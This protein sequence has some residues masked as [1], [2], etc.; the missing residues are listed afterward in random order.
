MTYINFVE[1][2]SLMLQ[3]HRP[4]GSG[5]EDFLKVL[6]IYSH[7]GHLG[8]VTWIIYINFLS[9]FIRMLHM[10][11]GFD[12]QFQRRRSLKLWTTTTPDAFGSGELKM[13][14]MKFPI[15]YPPNSQQI[16]TLV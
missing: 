3:S 10:K 5:E 4:S 16:F 15:S 2:L 6:A 14:K 11:F 1:L 13:A 9:P 8:H 7:G 12:K